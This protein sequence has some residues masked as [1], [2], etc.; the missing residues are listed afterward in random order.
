MMYSCVYAVPPYWK[1]NPMLVSGLRA[2]SPIVSPKPWQS[3][4]L[5]HVTG[6]CPVGS[7]Q[8]NVAGTCE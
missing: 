6:V 5:L 2:S 3:E 7:I 8:L 1:V 4:G